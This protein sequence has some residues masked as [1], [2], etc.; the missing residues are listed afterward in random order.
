[1]LQMSDKEWEALE[2]FQYILKVRR[3]NPSIHHR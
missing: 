1:M 3:I 2:D